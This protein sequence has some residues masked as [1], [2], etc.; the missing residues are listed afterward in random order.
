M[1]SPVLDTIR[2][3]VSDVLELPIERVTPE[4]VSEK[5]ENWDSVRHLSIMMSLEERFGIEL[6][7]EEVESMLS[8][9]EIERVI[10]RRTAG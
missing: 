10:L 1:T 6:E 5:V 7:P 4:M 2:Q 9:A 8:V 3:I